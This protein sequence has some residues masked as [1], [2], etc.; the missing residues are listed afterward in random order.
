MNN[1]KVSAPADI[2]SAINSHFIDQLALGIKPWHAFFKELPK[3]IDGQPFCGINIWLLANSCYSRNVFLSK[4]QMT[5]HKAIVKKG[6][7]GHIVV[8]SKEEK[9]KRSVKL[10]KVYNVD[11][12]LDIT[13]EMLP[14]L[15]KE[16]RVIKRC[17]DIY[18]NMPKH[19][20]D[21]EYASSVYYSVNKDTIYL[22]LYAT[23]E[24]DRKYYSA[25]FYALVQST[26]HRYRLNRETCEHRNPDDPK[27]YSC[28]EL[29]AEMGCSLLCSYAGIKP[30]YL[31]KHHAE[32]QGWLQKML[33]DPILVSMAA[34]RADEAVEYILN[35]PK[36]DLLKNRQ[37]M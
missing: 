20:N 24:D 14:P 21:I 29:I 31:T 18:N 37:R 2:Y 9:G 22:P 34:M 13:E 27:L 10:E 1:K 28:E 7:R 26:G 3:D 11:Q 23:F 25:F 15:E 17:A 19:P 4:P 35:I 36:L 30:W 33:N 12:V 5:R 8:T 32:A 16:Q 6:E